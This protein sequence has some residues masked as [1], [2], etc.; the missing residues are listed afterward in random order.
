MISVKETE[1]SRLIYLLNRICFHH[2][3]SK[4]NFVKYCKVKK[5]MFLSVYLGYI[6]CCFKMHRLLMTFRKKKKLL[7][8]MYVQVWAL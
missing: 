2:F 8:C 6:K 5:I 3:Q 4:C 1:K 7:L